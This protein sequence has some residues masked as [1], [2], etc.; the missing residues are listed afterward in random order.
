MHLNPDDKELW[1]D[2]L[3][4][5]Y[6]L[7]RKREQ[8]EEEK[9]KEKEEM[10][11]K[12][13]VKITEIKHGDEVNAADECGPEEDGCKIVSVCKHIGSIPKIDAGDTVK[14]LPTNYVQMR[15]LPP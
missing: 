2:D 4:W 6:S 10:K 11:C 14:K 12:A 3:L 1:E 13:C 7:L 8:L 9:R 5:A 15:D